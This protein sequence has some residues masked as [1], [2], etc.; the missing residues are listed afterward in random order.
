MIILFL[1]KTGHLWAQ[2]AYRN[3]LHLL[4]QIETTGS[5]PWSRPSEN[6][7]PLAAAMH[8]T[9]QKDW[10]IAEIQFK[11]RTKNP[12]YQR[13]KGLGKCECVCVCARRNKVI[14]V[15]KRNL[16]EN[17]WRRE[18]HRIQH[19]PW[20]N[21]TQSD[22]LKKSK[23]IISWNRSKQTCTQPMFK[24]IQNQ[25]VPPGHVQPWPLQK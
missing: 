8:L 20:E 12:A 1:S 4:L 19:A 5:S 7:V 18:T 11:A 14:T 6:Q 9:C 17:S 2:A 10:H 13:L 3:A 23:E 16:K 25:K 24:M 21:S 22:W 15:P